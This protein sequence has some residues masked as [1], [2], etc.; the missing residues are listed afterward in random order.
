MIKFAL[1]VTAILTTSSCKSILITT[2]L[3]GPNSLDQR[4]LSPVPEAAIGC[5]EIPD[6]STISIQTGNI[7]ASSGTGRIYVWVD[8]GG[9]NN[10]EITIPTSAE[11]QLKSF[12]TDAKT[13]PICDVPSK[14]ANPNSRI[15]TTYDN[16][17][18]SIQEYTFDTSRNV[19]TIGSYEVTPESI[20]KSGLRYALFPNWSGSSEDSKPKYPKSQ[21]LDSSNTTILI[22]N[23]QITPE[24]LFERLQIKRNAVV[25]EFP[26]V[27]PRKCMTANMTKIQL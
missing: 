26:K 21:F 3:C 17:W 25:F 27:D 12:M 22:D 11:S 15:V 6:N 7:F 18:H 24:A 1:I 2:P 16:G 4:P 9:F 14:N 20:K 8:K 23:S 13:M 10:A 19:M 5:Y